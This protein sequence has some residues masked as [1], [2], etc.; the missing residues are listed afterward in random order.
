MDGTKIRK[1]SIGWTFYCFF[2]VVVV[3]FCLFV[4]FFFGGGGKGGGD[5][6]E[7][8]GDVHLLLL[9]AK[10]RNYHSNQLS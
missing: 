9:K 5:N 1:F 3:V 7:H 8:T 10:R 4:F 6:L 2:V